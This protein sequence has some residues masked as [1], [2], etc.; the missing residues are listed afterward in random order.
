MTAITSRTFT[1][2]PSFGI[3]R[4]ARAAAAVFLAGSRLL[5]RLLARQSSAGL[6]GPTASGRH[7]REAQEVRAIAHRWERSDPGFAADLYAAAA[8]HE[9]LDD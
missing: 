6:S 8:R 5:H 9:G 4:G 3:P 1:P 2:G 7:A